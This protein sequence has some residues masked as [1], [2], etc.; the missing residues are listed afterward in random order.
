MILPDT[1]KF[2]TTIDTKGLAK[3]LDASGYSMCSFKTAEFVGI[4]NGGEFAYK[5]TYYD[6]AGTGKEE[7]GKVF[8][9]FDHTTLS[10][11]ADF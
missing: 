5:V 7:V 3:V 2:L 10:L 8:V 11:S 9:K 4:T 1:L 6:E